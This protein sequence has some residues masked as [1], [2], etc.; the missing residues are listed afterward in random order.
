MDNY[1]SFILNKK[2]SN[3]FTGIIYDLDP[4]QVLIYPAD[5]AINC[6]ATNGLLGLSVGSNVILMK[7]GNQFIITSII[8]NSFNDSIILNRS[9]TQTITDTNQTKIQFNNQKILIGNRLSFDAVNYGVKIGKGV[10]YVNINTD[11]WIER[12][13]GSYSSIHIKKNSTQLTYAIAPAR[14]TGQEGW[15]TQH[16]QSKVAV[17]ENDLI[18]AYVRFSSSHGSENIV[19][20]GY[21]DSCNLLV[22]AIG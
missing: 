17:V 20:G 19:A 1:L 13:T 10:N 18:Y 8:G 3:F 6:K 15:F 7:I 16:S 21:A 5:D 9:S 11:L 14:L 2:E 4:L 22:E 12:T